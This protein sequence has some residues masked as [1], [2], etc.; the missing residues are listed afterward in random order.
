MIRYTPSGQPVLISYEDITVAVSDRFDFVTV[1]SDGELN[2]WECTEEPILVSGVYRHRRA[3]SQDYHQTYTK[4]WIGNFE[5]DDSKDFKP[6][7]W[8]F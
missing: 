2:G 7:L 5:R 6:Q 3:H 8:K 1:D 4:S